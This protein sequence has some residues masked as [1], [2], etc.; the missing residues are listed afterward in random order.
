M[1]FI[2]VLHHPFQ[3]LYHKSNVQFLGSCNKSTEEDSN[4]CVPVIGHLAAFLKRDV[5]TDAI[6]ATKN[7]VL[8]NIKD[9]MA[10]NRYSNI[11]STVYVSEHENKPNQ[12]GKNH[13]NDDNSRKSS[14]TSLGSGIGFALLASLLCVATLLS[15][16]RKQKQLKRV[17]AEG[18][19]KGGD[20][21]GCAAHLSFVDQQGEDEH[22]PEVKDDSCLDRIH[23][24]H[25]SELSG[26]MPSTVMYPHSNSYIPSIVESNDM[27]AQN[28]DLVYNNLGGN[29][30]AN[31][32]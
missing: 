12:L 25:S 15:L 23:D 26:N 14:N 31:F 32:A 24:D 11:K 3:P 6:I 29:G 8:A 2:R 1:C 9:G 4:A 28:D 22:C 17:D 27:S 5:S 10:S 21:I 13:S 16:K 30:S 7:I 18:H 20:T 19:E